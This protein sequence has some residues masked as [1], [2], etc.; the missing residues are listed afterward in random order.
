VAQPAFQQR[1]RDLGQTPSTMGPGP[2]AGFL[3]EESERYAALV[4]AAN[5]QPQ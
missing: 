1:V 2:M 3:R 4:R 5:I